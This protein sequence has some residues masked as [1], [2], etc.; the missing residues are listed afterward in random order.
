MFATPTLSEGPF[1][2]QILKTAL[3]LHYRI[4]VQ[5]GDRTAGQ[6]ATRLSLT[7]G[8][9]TNLIDRLEQHKL[10]SRYK[11]SNDRRKVM[12]CVNPK[13]IE[14]TAKVYRSIGEAF[15]ELLNHYS[16]EELH[17]LIDHFRASIEM[18]K[19]EIA[20]LTRE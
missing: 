10:V 20:K 7:T 17:F 12:V 9:V 6:I 1:L 16:I 8:A 13:A 14:Q 11:D 2:T 4:L 18:T 5:E 19:R 15:S 3:T